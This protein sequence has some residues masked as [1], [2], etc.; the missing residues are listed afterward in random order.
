SLG[1]VSLSS[2]PQLTFP[3]DLSLGKGI[4]ATCRWEKLRNVAE[5]CGKWWWRFRVKKGALWI[6]VISSIYGCDG[7]GMG[8][9]MEGVWNDIIRVGK[10]LN[11]LNEG[12]INHLSKMIGNGLG[13]SFWLDKWVGNG[14]LC[15]H[16]SRLYQLERDKEV[17]VCNRGIRVNGVWEWKWGWARNPRGMAFNSLKVMD[18]SG[19]N[20]PVIGID[21]GTTYSCVAVSKHN[22]NLVEIIPNDQG[23][24]TTP[25]AVAFVGD[26]E[27][28]IG[29]AA[30]NQAAINPTNTI[31][32]AKR[33]IGRKFSDSQVQ[34]DMKL[35][36]FRVIEGS[37]DTPEIVVTYKGQEQDFRAEEISSMT[38]LGKGEHF[39]SAGASESGG[40][41]D[42]EESADDQ[43]DE[44]EDGD[45]DMKWFK[46]KYGQLQEILEFKYFLFKVV[47]FRVKWFD[48]QNQ[49]R[50]VKLLVFRNNM[51]Q[52]DT[53]G[54]AFK[55]DQ[56][57]LVTHVKQVFYLE[58]KVKPHWKVVEH[59]NHKKFFDGGVIVVE[60][61][62]DIIHFNN[63]SDLS[64]STS[65]NDLDNATL[66]IDGQSIEV[67]APPDIINVVEEDDDII[68]DEDALSH[69]LADS[70][71]E[72]LINVDDDGVTKFILV[73]K[74]IDLELCRQMLHSP[75]AVTVAVRIIPHHTMYPLVAGVA[76]LTEKRQMKA[77]FGRQGSGQAEYPRQDSNLSL[78][79]IT[80]IKG[81]V[82]IWFEVREKQ[83]LCLSVPKERKASLIADI[84]TQFDLRPHME[85]PDWTEIHAD[86]QQHMQKAYNTNKAAFKAQ[87]WVIDPTTGTYNVWKI[88]RAHPQD[89]TA[90]EWDKGRAQPLRST[91]R[92]LTP[93]SWHTLLTGNSFG[94]RTDEEMRRLEATGTYIDDEINRLARG[95]KQRGHILGVGRVLPAQATA[96]PNIS[97]NQEQSGRSF[98]R[99]IDCVNT[100]T[101]G[102]P[103]SLLGCG[104]VISVTQRNTCIDSGVPAFILKGDKVSCYVIGGKDLMFPG[105][106][107]GAEGLPELSAGETRDDIVL[108]GSTCMS[109]SEALKAGLSGKALKISHH[110]RDAL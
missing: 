89:I 76:S 59:V 40:S 64:R 102:K 26:S 48:T 16:F 110:Y 37:H 79:K 32:D 101:E 77:Q 9:D 70:D 63:S 22:I 95:G 42:D 80:D 109:R 17:M 81:P 35:W 39:E 20:A 66:H 30:K 69:D 54:E 36:P 96:N 104:I 65:L 55:N 8:G 31:F 61:D 53:K 34:E 13:T 100:A 5:E 75:T 92:S 21:L 68:D 71:D 99:D 56:Y 47:L 94:M 11:A 91:H 93:S 38:L 90:D 33:L 43:E 6:R 52:I 46:F 4:P 62:P 15:D 19:N 72:D 45:G 41:G 67:D 49:G 103:A 85:S 29:D 50:K 23:N 24:R 3:S 51:T 106:N 84:E 74:K 83:S 108:V 2:I 58:D 25:S 73:K 88:R 27:R 14:R 28:L 82:P 86:I 97:E 1:K 7:G 44:D 87:H 12:F 98:Y 57:I 107:I 10:D 78:K 60:D 105:I 18:G